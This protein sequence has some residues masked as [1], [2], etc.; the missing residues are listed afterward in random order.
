MC[1]LD[2]IFHFDEVHAILNEIIQG[3]LVLETNINEIVS[4]VQV[5]SKARKMSLQS[6]SSATGTSSTAQGAG[7]PAIWNAPAGLGGLPWSD[8]ASHVGGWAKVWGSKLGR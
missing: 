7:S 6:A 2:L 4:S 1:E 5:V 3:G 8:A